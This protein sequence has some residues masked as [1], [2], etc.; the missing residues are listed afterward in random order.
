MKYKSKQ[1]NS[2]PSTEWCLPIGDL[3][4]HGVGNIGLYQYCNIHPDWLRNCV[5]STL[6]LKGPNQGTPIMKK[7]DLVRNSVPGF[8]KEYTLT[9][10]EGPCFANC[11]RPNQ[12]S[13]FTVYSGLAS[14]FCAQTSR[15]PS[16][17]SPFTHGSA[18]RTS[19]CLR[20]GEKRSLIHFP[21]LVE[22]NGRKSMSYLVKVFVHTTT[23]QI[24]G[25]PPSPH[26]Q[27]L[28]YPPNGNWQL[29]ILTKINE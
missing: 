5:L 26:Q 14:T 13:T 9:E 17:T 20:A 19:P 7:G 18:R 11:C 12:M 1:S 29:T 4:K 10:Q 27:P 22:E 8:C 2:T 3:I 6:L 28:P 23:Y 24:S 15:K 21:D 25:I 16:G